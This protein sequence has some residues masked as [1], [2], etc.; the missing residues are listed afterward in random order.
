MKT[1]KLHSSDT[2]SARLRNGAAI[3]A[4]CRGYKIGYKVDGTVSEQ[5]ETG[6][7]CSL[8]ICDYGKVEELYDTS[9]TRR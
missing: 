8:I 1:K 7:N 6:L 5:I 3:L 9:A 4:N 2:K